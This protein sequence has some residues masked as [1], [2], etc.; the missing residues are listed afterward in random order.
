MTTTPNTPKRQGFYLT[1]AVPTANAAPAARRRLLAHPEVGVLLQPDSHLEDQAH[2]F[3]AVGVDN[4]CYSLGLR[5]EVFDWDTFAAWLATIPRTVQFVAVPDVLEWHTD[6]KGKRF[7]VGNAVATLAQFPV[8]A[9]RIA[10]LGF[11]PALVL[12]DGMEALTIPWDDLGA[13]FVGGSDAW[14]LGPAAAALCAEAKRRGKWVH[15]GRV[16]S[17]KRYRWALEQMGADSA[18][19]TLLAFGADENVRRLLSEPSAKTGQV[20]R[21]LTPVGELEQAAA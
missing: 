14:K 2:L 4:G 19:G 20:T 21:W 3:P 11:V 10:A 18:D 1:G 12:Q 9:P 5:G 13:V 8:Y 6:E 7:P 15:V 17:A 16:N